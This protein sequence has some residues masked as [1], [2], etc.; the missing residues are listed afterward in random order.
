MKVGQTVELI[1]MENDPDPIP[2]GTK[3]KITK[4][5]P[6]PFD[7]EIQLCVDWEN[8]RKLMLIYPVDKFKIV[9]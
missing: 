5:N 4:V 1:S 2:S 6:T 8:G 9:G 7:G 3:G